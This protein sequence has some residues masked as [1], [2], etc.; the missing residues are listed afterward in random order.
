MLRRYPAGSS[1]LR[2][3]QRFDEIQ[4]MIGRLE[5]AA[6]VASPSPRITSAVVDR[7][8]GDA[9]TLL[10]SS[11]ATS[12]VDRIHTALH[13]YLRAVCDDAHI[14]YTQDPS[15]TEL[16]RLL[17]QN[18]PRLQRAVQHSPEIDRIIR[19]FSSIVD[20]LN[21]LRNRGSVAHPNPVLLEHDEALLAINAARTVLHYLDAKLSG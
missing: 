15:I 7:A 3:Q 14:S 8:I 10:R 21:T 20:A 19:G 1:E 12:G 9:E 18:H 6:L 5:G 11:G 13:G 17:R 2:T 16:F 4:A